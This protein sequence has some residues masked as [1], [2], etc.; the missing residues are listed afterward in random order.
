VPAVTGIIKRSIASALDLDITDPDKLS[1]A[2]F[3][4]LELEDRSKGNPVKLY[5]ANEVKKKRKKQQEKFE[6]FKKKHKAATTGII[7]QQAR[8]KIKKKRTAW[9]DE[10][11]EGDIVLSHHFA[12]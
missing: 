6:K 1:S 3:A 10:A 7:A 5:D 11:A 8:K 2:G 4:W 9:E 12:I